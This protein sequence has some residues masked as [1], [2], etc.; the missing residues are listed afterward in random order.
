MELSFPWSEAALPVIGLDSRVR[1]AASQLV[2]DKQAIDELAARLTEQGE[3]HTGV[4][5]ASIGWIL[6]LLHDPDGGKFS[7]DQ[8]ARPFRAMTFFSAGAGTAL[9]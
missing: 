2:P 7:P 1:V 6:P 4:H 5:W 3:Q 9:S 8:Q